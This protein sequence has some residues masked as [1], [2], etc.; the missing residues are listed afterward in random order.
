MPLRVSKSALLNAIDLSKEIF[1]AKLILL[2]R[3]QE[4]WGEHFMKP[5]IFSGSENTF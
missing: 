5:P 4:L 1:R 3:T 2:L